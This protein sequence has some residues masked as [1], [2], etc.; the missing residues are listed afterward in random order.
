MPV[1]RAEGIKSLL[2]SAPNSEAT[3]ASSMPSILEVILSSAL[4]SEATNAQ[5]RHVVAAGRPV[6]RP[7]FRGDQCPRQHEPIAP[8]RQHSVPPTRIHGTHASRE[9]ISARS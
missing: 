1:L 8:T 3:N 7:Q 6:V 5:D 9:R 4:N 2:S